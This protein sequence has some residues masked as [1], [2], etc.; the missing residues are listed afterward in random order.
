MTANLF[1]RRSFIPHSD[2]L[3]LTWRV[4]ISHAQAGI[5]TWEDLSCNHEGEFIG[6][7]CITF[8]F[9]DSPLCVFKDKHQRHL[10]EY[11]RGVWVALQAI[12]LVHV[13]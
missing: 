13:H 7:V 2:R 4:S 11:V 6:S 12:W 5:K 3:C 9:L 10:C 8:F 1:L